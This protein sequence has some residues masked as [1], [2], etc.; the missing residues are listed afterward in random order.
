MGQWTDLRWF[1]F[2]TQWTDLRWFGFA[3]LPH[4][5]TN[6]EDQNW[7]SW[8]SNL[9]N[10]RGRRKFSEMGTPNHPFIDGSSTRNHFFFRKVG[11]VV[12]QKILPLMSSVDPTASPSLR[13]LWSCAWHRRGCGAGATFQG[14][15]PRWVECIA[16]MS[17]KF[18]GQ[19]WKPLNPPIQFYFQN[20]FR[21]KF[22]GLRTGPWPFISRS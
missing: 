21:P 18:Y 6:T 15:Q 19:S 9:P 22:L 4:F 12:H 16:K 2:A 10:V 11:S 20:Q 13:P 7:R 3:T 17:R 14:Q 8:G 5:Q 1:G